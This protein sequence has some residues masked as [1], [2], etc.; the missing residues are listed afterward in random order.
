MDNWG[1][2]R[3][4]YAYCTNDMLEPSVGYRCLDGL[5]K[6]LD[7][8]W[9]GGC[10]YRG[11][12]EGQWGGVNGYSSDRSEWRRV[13]L[14]WVPP[15]RVLQGPHLSNPQVYLSGKAVCIHSRV[16]PS[17]TPNW[18]MSPSVTTCGAASMRDHG[19]VE[20]PLR[21]DQTP[22]GRVSRSGFCFSYSFCSPVVLWQKPCENFL[23]SA[24]RA[25]SNEGDRMP[26]SR[27]AAGPREPWWASLSCRSLSCNVRS[28]MRSL[29][30]SQ[31]SASTRPRERKARGCH[32]GR[33]SS[34]R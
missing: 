11:L 12:G 22:S 32:E 34:S 21:F 20:A 25:A 2:G 33:E 29:S 10:E 31:L 9:E 3:G 18:Y 24:R 5:Q 13:T 1:C 27:A 6:G 15:T 4:D 14:M 7:A 17:K 19:T 26:A 28:V 30:D 16:L 23:T 8:F